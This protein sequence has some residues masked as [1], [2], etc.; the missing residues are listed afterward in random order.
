MDET[1]GTALR[2]ARFRSGKS[3]SEM[4]R[5]IHVSK[6]ALDNYELGVRQIPEYVIV[7]YWQITHDEDVRTVAV[8]SALMEMVEFYTAFATPPRVA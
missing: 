2:N 6:S 7:A 1:I 3:L 4:A 5:L 8:A